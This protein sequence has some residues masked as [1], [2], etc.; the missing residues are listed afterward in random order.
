M[1]NAKRNEPQNRHWAHRSR[2]RSRGQGEG[3]TVLIETAG[4]T[5]VFGEV[6][7]VDDLIVAIP[8]GAIGLVGPKGAGKTNF[9]RLLLGLVRQRTGRATYL[10]DEY[11]EYCHCRQ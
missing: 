9:L 1:E 2:R 8:E 7:A 11:T 10:G 5:K 3:T 4:L 6:R